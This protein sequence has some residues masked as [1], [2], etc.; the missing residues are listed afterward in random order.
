MTRKIS[1][2]QQARFCE[3]L[4]DAAAWYKHLPLLQG[5][6][7]FIF[8]DDDAGKNYPI[9]PPRL[10]TGNTKAVYQ[11]AFGT[12][13]FAWS[14]GDENEFHSIGDLFE[15]YLSEAELTMRFPNHVQLRIFPYVSGDFIESLS[16]H[17]SDFELLRLQQKT[18][19]KPHENRDLLLELERLHERET[20]LWQIV[21][22]EIEREEI[23]YDI[24]HDE[25]SQE[26]LEYKH[27]T[28]KIVDVVTELQ[29]AEMKKIA[30]AVREL[31]GQ[32]EVAWAK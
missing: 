8:T 20:Y 32:V 31:C 14:Q 11:I 26:R 25:M 9:K 13:T 10:S 23:A 21:F 5:G 27:I 4:T 3:Y 15:G 19:E 28:Q 18:G 22:T 30:M 24:E 29:E 12:L 17:K 6:Q 2:E 16:F 7:F 1:Q